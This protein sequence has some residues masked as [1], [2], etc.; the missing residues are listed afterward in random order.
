MSELKG[1]EVDP[2]KVVGMDVWSFVRFLGA[3]VR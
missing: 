3:S 1:E 2:E